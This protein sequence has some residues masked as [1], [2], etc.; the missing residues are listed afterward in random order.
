MLKEEQVMEVKTHIPKR[1]EAEFLQKLLENC[2]TH[3]E[4]L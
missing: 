2:K 4:L 1:S 3:S